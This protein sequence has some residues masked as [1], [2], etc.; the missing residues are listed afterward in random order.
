MKRKR[1][2]ADGLGVALD[3]THGNTMNDLSKEGIAMT[4]RKFSRKRIGQALGLLALGLVVLVGSA[5]YGQTQTTTFPPSVAVETQVGTNGRLDVEIFANTR[6]QVDFMVDGT[7][8]TLIKQG[9]SVV[10]VTTGTSGKPLR[11][12]TITSIQSLVQGHLVAVLTPADFTISGGSNNSMAGGPIIITPKARTSGGQTKLLHNL[13]VA[14][15]DSGLLEPPVGA[16]FKSNKLCGCEILK[17]SVKIE[18]PK[19]YTSEGVNGDRVNDVVKSYATI[20]VETKGTG[21]IKFDIKD[22]LRY[23]SVYT[24]D[25]LTDTERAE[26]FTLQSSVDAGELV[27][28]KELR[29]IREPREC[30]KPIIM[31]IELRNLILR[32]KDG[33]KEKPGSD[34]NRK[35]NDISL[36]DYLTHLGGRRGWLRTYLT[37][38][39]SL[40]F[41]VEDG[42]CSD[43]HYVRIIYV[44]G[45]FT[46]KFGGGD[47]YYI[48]PNTMN[49]EGVGLYWGKKK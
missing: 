20:T 44:L 42:G 15:D 49:V 18:G 8:H 30:G 19:N 3:S 17:I 26:D 13:V 4:S 2:E 39:F 12:D 7:T 21:T 37:T 10:I 11:P 38:A 33:D 16:E 27:S 43:D 34:H 28:P 32:E 47:T 14:Q 23:L 40:T 41:K 22:V 5:G 1:I 45:P 25:E 6:F 46:I 31:R 35:A 29:R 9:I 48:R 36:Q 24:Y